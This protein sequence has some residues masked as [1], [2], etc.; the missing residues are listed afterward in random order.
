MIAFDLKV[1]GNGVLIIDPDDPFIDP[2]PPGGGSAPR[3]DR[4]GPQVALLASGGGLADVNLPSSALV[5]GSLESTRPA[6]Q[7]VLDQWFAS[8]RSATEAG[9]LS[10][11]STGVQS[12]RSLAQWLHPLSEQVVDNL[13]SSLVPMA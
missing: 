1:D 6:P 8:R 12:M 7:T 11:E 2:P 4:P 3:G 10:G 13:V 9:G 5:T